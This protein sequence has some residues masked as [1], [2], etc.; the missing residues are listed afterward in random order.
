MSAIPGAARLPQAGSGFGSLETPRLPPFCHRSPVPTP[1]AYCPRRPSATR[2]ATAAGL[3]DSPSLGVRQLLGVH[4]A[5]EG[6]VAQP[7]THSLQRY[8]C[9][10]PPRRET[11]VAANGSQPLAA[12][13]LRTVYLTCCRLRGRIGFPSR[14]Q[15]TMSEAC[16]ATPARRRIAAAA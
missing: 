5:R 15:N 14:V 6:I 1:Q 8:P 7:F 12:P 16:H 4:A 11:C 3:I 2:A 10:Q 13:F 9:R